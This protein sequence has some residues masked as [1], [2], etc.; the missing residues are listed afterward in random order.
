MY[1]IIHRF[2]P[3]VTTDE[4]RIIASKYEWRPG[5]TRRHLAQDNS[6]K[7]LT[8]FSDEPLLEEED[9]K[10]LCFMEASELKNPI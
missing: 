6:T 5:M 8:I 3:E 7:T 4:F 9:C 2:G 10:K 1:K